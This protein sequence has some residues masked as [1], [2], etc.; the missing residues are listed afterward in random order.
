MAQPSI[1][2][3][4]YTFH[5]GPL[6]AP[7]LH[8][9]PTPRCDVCDRLIP[10]PPAGE[11]VYLWAR[12]DEARYEPA[13]LCDTCATAIGIAALRRFEEDEEEGG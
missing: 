8:T 1:P 10:G 13:P 12:G 5:D 4:V 7:L 3:A 9:Q 2:S 11:G 6:P